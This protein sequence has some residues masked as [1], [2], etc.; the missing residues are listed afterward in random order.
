MT[1]SIIIPART[2]PLVLIGAPWLIAAVLWVV[3]TL[4]AC[5]GTQSNAEPPRAPA[6]V[7]AAPDAGLPAPVPSRRGVIVPSDTGMGSMPS[8]P[9]PTTGTAG[10][11]TSPMIGNPG[12]GGN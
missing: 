7:S 5:G 11:G 1:N 8:G 4:P 10:R 2:R 6:A 12:G 3:A 9:G